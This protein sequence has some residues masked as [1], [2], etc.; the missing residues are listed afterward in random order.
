MGVSV[1]RG[2]T[3]LGAVEF[4]YLPTVSLQLS[5]L[6]LEQLVATEPEAIHVVIWDRAG[7]HLNLEHHQLPKQI[8]LLPLPAY[9]PELN[10]MER[11]WD[12]VKG[13]VSNAIWETLDAIEE[14]MTEVLRPFWQSTERVRGFLGDNWLTQGVATFLDQLHQTNRPILN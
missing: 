4:L 10:P 12:Q 7:F 1:W 13:E 6:F 5:R 2:R 9:C 11:L 3:G 8:R 14:P